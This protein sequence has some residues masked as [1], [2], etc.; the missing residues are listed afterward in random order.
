[1][2]D[3]NKTTNRGDRPARRRVVITGMGALSPVGNTA[4]ETW[5]SFVAGKSGAARVESFDTRPFAAKIAAEIKGFDAA[6]HIDPKEAKRMARCSQLAIVAAREAVAASGLDFGREDRERVAVA[7]GTGMG[8]IDILVEPIGK[9]AAQGGARVTPHQALES[10]SHIAGFHV[11][12]EHGCLGPLTTIITACAAGAQAIGEGVEW[13][14]RGA[15]DV[16]LA[17][18][19]EAQVNQLFFAGFGALRV[20]STRNDE[21]ERATRPFDAERDGFVIGEAACIMVLEELERAKARGARIYAEVLG[22]AASADAYH[23]AQPEPTGLGPARCMRWALED[24]GVPPEAIQYINAHGTATQQNDPAETAG[25]KRVFGDYAYKIPISSTKSMTGHCFGGGSA[26]EAFAT[27]MSV[28]TGVIHP[29]I[30]LEHADPA[31]DLDY[32]PNQ[33]RHS[34]VD[35][36]MTNSFGFGG[37]N[38]CLVLGKYTG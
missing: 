16:V 5:A 24:A 32:V 10:L 25:I 11:S 9:F 34:V 22:A 23:I 21:P 26:L 28:C 4:P 17:G 18:G 12:L 38:A 31:C 7:M 36:A 3:G 35:V 29:T 37:Q 33:A 13:I 27:V 6:K 30:N 15:A 1:M 20:L 19:S 2:A 14:R 8:G